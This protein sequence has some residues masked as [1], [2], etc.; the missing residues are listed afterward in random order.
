MENLSEQ[1]ARLI[2]A[3]KAY[4]AAIIGCEIAGGR[5]Q[6]AIVEAMPEELRAVAQSPMMKALGGL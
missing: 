5:T 4:F 2:D 6:D 3:T 1:E